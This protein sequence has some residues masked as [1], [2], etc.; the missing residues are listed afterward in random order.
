MGWQ[1]VPLKMFKVEFM[2]G[3]IVA[4][5]ATTGFVLKDGSSRSCKDLKSGDEFKNGGVVAS[6]TEAGEIDYFLN[7]EEG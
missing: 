1:M 7:V 2:G 6:V 4:G 5:A 3:T